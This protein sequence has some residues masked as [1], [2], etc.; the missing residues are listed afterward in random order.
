MND[1]DKKIIDDLIVKVIQEIGFT[2]D[3][4]ED[5]ITELESIGEIYKAI[6][7]IAEEAID[8]HEADRDPDA[9]SIGTENIVEDMNIPLLAQLK[10]LDYNTLKEIVEKYGDNRYLKGATDPSLV[11]GVD[12]NST[13]GV[14]ASIQK[15]TPRSSHCSSYTARS[16]TAIPKTEKSFGSSR[17]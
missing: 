16:N 15:E 17:S 4:A 3:K 6:D 14:T 5:L 8:E 7:T 10:T 1:D 13:K 12:V 11:K 2:E 9:D